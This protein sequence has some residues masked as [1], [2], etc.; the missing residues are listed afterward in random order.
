[1]DNQLVV[2]KRIIMISQIVK[3]S[4][5]CVKNMARLFFKEKKLFSLFFAS[6]T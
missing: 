3:Q 6:I 5:N 1:M 4:Q 2:Y